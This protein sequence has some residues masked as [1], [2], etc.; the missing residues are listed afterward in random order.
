MK[1]KIRAA[2]KHRTQEKNR[3]FLLLDS[4]AKPGI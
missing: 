2:K 1:F 4:E 3:I